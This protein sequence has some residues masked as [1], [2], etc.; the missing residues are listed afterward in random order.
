M[1]EEI[2]TLEALLSHRLTGRVLEADGIGA[3]FVLIQRAFVAAGKK[4]PE[5][6][7][8]KR[9]GRASG[10][11]L[12]KLISPRAPSDQSVLRIVQGYRTSTRLN[13][14]RSSSR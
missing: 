6:E 9:V 12:L 14:A 7:D 5:A 11:H 3:E 2:P 4:I 8:F 10:T 13:W 1:S